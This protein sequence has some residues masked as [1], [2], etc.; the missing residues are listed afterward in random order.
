ML[1]GGVEAEPRKR[2]VLQQVE[3]PRQPHDRGARLGRPHG[4]AANEQDPAELLFERLDALR[5]RGRRD[6][7]RA[8]GRVE[9]AL[10]DDDGE[11]AGQ[12]ERNPHLKTC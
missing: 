11:G 4:F 1:R 12:I 2:L 5:D 3:L 9:R 7:Q 6:L 10:G 8:R